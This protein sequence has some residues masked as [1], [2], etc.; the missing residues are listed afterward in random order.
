M[1]RL[2]V[3][4]HYGGKWIKVPKLIYSRKFVHTWKGYDSDLLCFS[5][6]VDQ[7]KNLGFLGVQQLVVTGQSGKYYEMKF[8]TGIRTLLYLVGT[9]CDSANESLNCGSVNEALNS[10]SNESSDDDFDVEELE[11]NILQ[12]RRDNTLKLEHFK[13]IYH[14]MSFKDILEARMFINLY[15][16]AENKG[17]VL[18]KSDKFRVRYKCA[19]GCP[20]NVTSV[21]VMD[22]LVGNESQVHKWATDYSPTTL[23]IYKDFV[24]IDEN[25]EKSKRKQAI[26]K[27]YK[28]SNTTTVLESEDN[29]PNSSRT[30]TMLEPDP[31]LR[32]KSFSEANTRIL[33]RMKQALATPIRRISFVGDS[34]GMS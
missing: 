16:L 31:S 30:T 19:E 15:S 29:F 33:E 32:P 12:N 23:K 6:L 26:V 17:L 1:V 5:D 25:C 7:F 27:R 4:F 22:M 28:G 21:N 2:V 14:G 9:D 11:L 8:N 10:S 18:L 13:I 3:N 24:V 34:T 20:F